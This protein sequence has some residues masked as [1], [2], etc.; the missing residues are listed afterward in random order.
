MC[1]RVSL[2]YLVLSLRRYALVHAKPM[3]AAFF[4]MLQ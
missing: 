4:S 2:L 3:S 1:V